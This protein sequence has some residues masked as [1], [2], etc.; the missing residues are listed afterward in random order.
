MGVTDLLFLFLYKICVK[1]MQAKAPH[2][3]SP[4]SV[5][6]QDQKLPPRGPRIYALGLCSSRVDA[7]LALKR[8]F[9]TSFP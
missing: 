7:L 3:H 9:E 8:L 5:S 1:Y 4:Q 6:N 2:R